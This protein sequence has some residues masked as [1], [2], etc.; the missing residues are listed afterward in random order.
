MMMHS[1]SLPASSLVL[2]AALS[3]GTG[4]R[5][6]PAAAGKA[7]AL[8]DIQLRMELDAANSKMMLSRSDHLQR[9]VLKTA[10]LL[11]RRS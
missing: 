11:Q 10:S 2:A 3:M 5:V 9:I 7:L 6:S 4:T 8:D 1:F